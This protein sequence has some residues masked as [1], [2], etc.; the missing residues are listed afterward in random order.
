MI[1]PDGSIVQALLELNGLA[2]HHGDTGALAELWSEHLAGV[3]RLF[4]V[5]TTE[6][7]PA[8]TFGPRWD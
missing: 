4:D 8:V 2:T 3:E 5:H 6:I 7:E 1:N